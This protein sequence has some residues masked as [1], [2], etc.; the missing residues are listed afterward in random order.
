MYRVKS[1]KLYEGKVYKTRGWDSTLNNNRGGT[2][3]FVGDRL[4]SQNLNPVTELFDANTPS[5]TS[6]AEATVVAR[7]EI[8]IEKIAEK[9]T[10]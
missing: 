10:K 6:V 2:T 7:V 8:I 1:R 4:V 3:D 5:G 9:E